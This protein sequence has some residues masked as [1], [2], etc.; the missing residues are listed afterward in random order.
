MTTQ[1][2]ALT[3]R[4][5]HR[6]LGFFLAGIMMIYAISGVLLIFRE[7]AFLKYEYQLEE[8]LSPNL[9]SNELREALRIKRFRVL[10]KTAEA[11]VFEAGRYDKATGIA[12]Y[13][14]E[15]YP[16]PLQKMVSLHKAT[17]NSPLYFLNIAFGACLLFFAVSAFFMFLPKL[18]AYKT[19]L[20]VAVAGALFAVIVVLAA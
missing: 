8:Q 5:Y 15:Q 6:L 16:Q 11:V 18:P 13:S 14:V 20:K 3:F 12:V 17:T 19:G 7:T 2:T 9:S 4:K 1:K 10:E